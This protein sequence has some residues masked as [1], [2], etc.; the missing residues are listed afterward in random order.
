MK[1]AGKIIY[2]VW[3][4]II[5]ISLCF[6]CFSCYV[7]FQ[8]EKIIHSSITSKG[9]DYNAYRDVIADYDYLRMWH[10]KPNDASYDR[11]EFE[12]ENLTQEY[13]VTR[14]Y[15]ILFKDPQNIFSLS[16]VG[17]IYNNETVDI[18]GN[19]SYMIAEKNSKVVLDVEYDGLK[20][21]V[22]GIIYDNDFNDYKIGRCHGLGLLII[23]LIN[24]FAR[25]IRYFDRCALN[26]RKKN[27]FRFIQPYFFSIILAISFMFDALPWALAIG[28]AEEL[29]FTIVF[30]IIDKKTMKK[31]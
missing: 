29:L 26:R 22:N 4:V 1:I 3:A 15:I 27:I 17:Y 13:S 9:E 18:L 19:K 8:T 25:N 14:P 24:A 31:V 12:E 2:I 28:I 20:V 7:G 10:Q 30:M 5:A 23:L 21:K 11:V 16:N 6:Y